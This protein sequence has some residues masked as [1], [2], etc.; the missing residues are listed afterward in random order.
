VCVLG[1]GGSIGSVEQEKME[2]LMSAFYN[3]PF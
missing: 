3:D 2:V 1:G